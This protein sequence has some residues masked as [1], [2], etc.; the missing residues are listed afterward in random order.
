MKTKLLAIASAVALGVG[1]ITGCSTTTNAARGSN[2][3][4]KRH[5]IDAGVDAPCRASMRRI[6]PRAR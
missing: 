1:G 4:A 5:S 6:R 3:V 2:P